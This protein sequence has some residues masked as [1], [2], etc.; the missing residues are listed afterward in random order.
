MDAVVLPE[1]LSE[2]A[3]TDFLR[4]RVENGDLAL[5]DLPLRLARYGLMEPAA[6]VDEMR[7]R[8]ASAQGS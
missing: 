3:L 8:M 1:P 4:Q 6:F 7:E 5:D 2:D